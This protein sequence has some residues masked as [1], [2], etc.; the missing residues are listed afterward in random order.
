MILT[1]RGHFPF[2]IGYLALIIAG[3]SSVYFYN[4]GQVGVAEF[5]G[6]IGLVIGITAVV[7]TVH[8]YMTIRLSSRDFETIIFIF[9]SEPKRRIVKVLLKHGPKHLSELSRLCAMS[10]STVSTHALELERQAILTLDPSLLNGNT[11]VKVASIRPENKT[12]LKKVQHA[13]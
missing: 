12:L 3:G 2:L 6:L 11:L 7:V 5:V 10:I 8:T 13:I 9:S 1:L 4:M